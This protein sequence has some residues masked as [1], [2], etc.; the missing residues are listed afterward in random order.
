MS[1]ALVRHRPEQKVLKPRVVQV[2]VGSLVNVAL[3]LDLVIVAQ[4]VHFVNEHFELNVR[5]DLVSAC[6]GHV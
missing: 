1:S 5:I 2:V 6:H 3:S 4:A